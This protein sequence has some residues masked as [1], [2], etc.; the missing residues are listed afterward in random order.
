VWLGPV[1][2]G[3]RMKLVVNAW[4]V[5]LVA[6]L[7]ESIALAEGLDIDPSK[8]LEILEGSA[9]NSPY[10]Q[11]KGRAMIEKSF[12]PS[13]ALWLA[14]K[15]VGL[16]LEAAAR[17]GIEPH[18]ALAVA[19]QFDHAIEQGHGDEDFGAAYYGARAVSSRL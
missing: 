13:F 3:T 2:A 17:A 9:V 7:A 11:L 18:V 12:E 10:A 4:L 14:R 16:V 15:D 1:G 6:S 19:E 8:F 5:G